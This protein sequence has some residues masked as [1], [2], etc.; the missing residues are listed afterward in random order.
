MMPSSGFIFV[1]NR[2]AEDTLDF[3]NV[4]TCNFKNSFYITDGF[5]DLFIMH[6]FVDGF[7][8]FH[9]NVVS[10]HVGA[11]TSP[12]VTPRYSDPRRVGVQHQVASRIP[13]CARDG[14]EQGDSE[15][16]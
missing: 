12:K 4:F 9:F 16:Q 15:L 11:E 6:A 5:T 14:L 8:L 7:T 10:M 3:I 13:G 1:F 2:A